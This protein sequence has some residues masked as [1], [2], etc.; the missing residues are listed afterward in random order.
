MK[1]ALKIFAA[2]LAV[3]VVGFLTI[4]GSLYWLL[5]SSYPHGGC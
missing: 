4:A 5:C 3:A 1:T 2:A